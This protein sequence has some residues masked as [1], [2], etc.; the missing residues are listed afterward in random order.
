MGAGAFQIIENRKNP[1][2]IGTLETYFDQYF[3]H[4]MVAFGGWLYD[5][6]GDKFGY[7]TPEQLQQAFLQYEQEYG[8]PGSP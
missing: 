6:Y 1:E 5:Q 3:D 8:D 7:L 4:W 2:A